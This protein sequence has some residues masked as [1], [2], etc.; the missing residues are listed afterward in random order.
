[1]GFITYYIGKF[2]GNMDENMVYVG[3]ISQ[4]IREKHQ[5]GFTVAS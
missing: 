1:M 5:V 4:I 3:N 2:G